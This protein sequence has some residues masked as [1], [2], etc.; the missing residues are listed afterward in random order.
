[1]VQGSQQVLQTRWLPVHCDVIAPDGS[2]IR[3]LASAGQ[4]SMCHCSLPAGSL[5][6]AIIHRS[7]EEVWYFVSGRGQV[8]R[9]LGDG[10]ELVEVGPGCS[11]NIPTG[12]SFQFRNS[13][14]EPL[15]FVIVTMPP[16]PGEQE[17]VATS[18]YWPS[19]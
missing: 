9:K 2:E 12:A 17:A 19:P 13:G 18:G 7:V 10:H 1:M 15:C 6:K 8:W 16:W 11:L 4:G 3:L 14:D 5:S